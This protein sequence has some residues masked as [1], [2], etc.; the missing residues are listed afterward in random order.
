VESFGERLRTCRRQCW[1][2][3]RGGWLTQERLGELL[4][5]ELGDAGYSGAAVSDWERDRSK[6]HEDNRRVL[7]ALLAVLLRLGGLQSAGDANRLLRAGNYRELDPAEHEQLFGSPAIA[8]GAGAVVALPPVSAPPADPRPYERPAPVSAV[9]PTPERRKQ[10]ILLDKV[11]NFWVAGVLEQT[12]RD[13][14]P[15]ELAWECQEEAVQRPWRELLGPAAAVPHPPPG[16]GIVHVFRAADRALLILGEPGSGK[17]TLMLELAGALAAQALDDPA[18]AIPVVLNLVSWSERRGTIADWAVEEL[19]AKYQI[20]RGTGRRWLDADDLVLLLDGFDEVPAALRRACALALNR[21]RDEHGLTSLVVCSRV[22]EYAACGLRLKLG[23]AIRVRPLESAQIDTYLRTT[24]PGLAP[25]RSAVV[26]DDTL[27]ELARTPLM[28]KVMA[29]AY[30]READGAPTEAAPEPAGAGAL[31]AARR[32]LLAAYV[33]H[34]FQWSRAGGPPDP[35]ETSRRLAWFSRRLLEHNQSVFMLEQLQPSWLPP[36]PWRWTY[37]LAA[38]LLG[39]LFG[40][41]ILWLMWTVLRMAIPELPVTASRPV[42]ALTSLS[43]AEAEPVTLVAANLALGVVAATIHAL[44]F[45]YREP[46]VGA[47]GGERRKRGWRVASLGVVIGLLSTLVVALSTL[48]FESGGWQRGELL[49]LA[50]AWGVAE[51]VIFMFVAHKGFGYSYRTDIRPVEALGWSWAHAARGAGLGVVI[52][53]LAEVV[54]TLL[55]PPFNGALAN[56]SAFVLAGL[57]LGGMQGQRLVA[58]SRPNQ[59]IWLSARNG[60]LAA[61][62]VALPFG[63]LLAVYRGATAAWM[64]AVAMGLLALALFGG[65]NV[66]KHFILRLLLWLRGDLPWRAVSF[67]DSAAR[68]VLLRKVGGGYIFMHRLLQEYFAELETAAPGGAGGQETPGEDQRARAR[69]GHEDIAAASAA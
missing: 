56:L 40:G 41:P 35:R 5:S 26:H 51:A 60:V 33:R 17:T 11:R 23:E 52:A 32:H 63:L 67:L 65:G 6:L 15:F 48:L 25:L 3:L 64:A 16:E 53:V 1:D 28:L 43:L 50:L 29:V 39:G 55:F 59:G 18:E 38:W 12:T 2:P 57:L 61:L 21:F 22:D 37:L 8:P 10:L 66:A 45:D 31:S 68:L 4:G 13:R 27:R 62:V 58:K 42:A 44:F 36:G 54:Q 34:M 30:G 46:F 14:L 47:P 7:L 49:L 20:P 9:A 19:L 24:A 69:A